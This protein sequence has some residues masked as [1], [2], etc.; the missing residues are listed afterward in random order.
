M[1]NTKLN[2][3]LISGPSFAKMLLQKRQFLLHAPRELKYLRPFYKAEPRHGDIIAFIYP[4][5]YELVGIIGAVFAC[6]REDGEMKLHVMATKRK[7]SRTINRVY[8]NIARHRVICVLKQ[9]GMDL[10][11]KVGNSHESKRE[12]Q[13][14]DTESVWE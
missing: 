1:F 13:K 14:T 9:V 7:N 6:C 2:E 5:G 10:L 11:M 8:R 4:E 12:S 3:E